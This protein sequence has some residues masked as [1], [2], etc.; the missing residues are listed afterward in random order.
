MRKDRELG[1]EDLLEGHLRNTEMN[2]S[3]S[4]NVCCRSRE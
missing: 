2:L 1:H 4:S 3:E